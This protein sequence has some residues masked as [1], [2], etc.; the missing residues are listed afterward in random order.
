[1][2]KG[3]IGGFAEMSLTVPDQL[4]RCH[5]PQGLDRGRTGCPSLKKRWAR[6][7]AP[8]PFLSRR[9]NMDTVEHPSQMCLTP[10][11]NDPSVAHTSS[12]SADILYGGLR[13]VG[14]PAVD[15]VSKI[16]SFMHSPS[17]IAAARGLRGKE[18]QA[19]IDLIDQ[20]RAWL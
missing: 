12:P 8:I 14:V 7:T 3:G 2:G 10:Q 9:W 6:P 11:W 18:A 17:Q 4:L 16:R 13:V 20:V 5:S 15:S 19:F 1:V